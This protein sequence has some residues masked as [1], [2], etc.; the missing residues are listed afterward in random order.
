MEE[1]IKMEAERPMVIVVDS[2]AALA[3]EEE[4]SGNLTD[5][6]VAP[7]A[8]LLSRYLRGVKSRVRKSN[9]LFIFL[10]QLRDKVGVVWGNPSHS[11]GGR[12]LKYYASVRVEVSIG[13][14]LQRGGAYIG[15]EMKV[16]VAKVVFPLPSVP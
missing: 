14:K 12:S 8:R 1:K 10:N 2:V 16:R 9:T 4:L 15:H 13:K 6:K 11:T 7:V 3:T 5:F